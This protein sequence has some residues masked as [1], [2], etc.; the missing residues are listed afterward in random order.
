M[1][2]Q[3]SGNFNE[4]AKESPLTVPGRPQSEKPLLVGSLYLLWGNSIKNLSMQLKLGHIQD[5][6]THNKNFPPP[7]L[8]NSTKPLSSGPTPSTG[9]T[10]S[11]LIPPL[12]C[13]ARCFRSSCDSDLY[14]C[15][16]NTPLWWCQQ[17]THCT[18]TNGSPRFVKMPRHHLSVWVP[19]HQTYWG[20]SCQES[21]PVCMCLV[22]HISGP[23]T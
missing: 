21:G 16:S 2:A 13:S 5:L 11:W 17:E 3:S 15:H 6:N 20:H 1:A 8:Y 19:C 4:K 18:L 23:S 10:R 14:D 7:A 9:S 12:A 22:R